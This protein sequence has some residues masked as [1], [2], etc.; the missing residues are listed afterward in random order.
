MILIPRPH[1]VRRFFSAKINRHKLALS[2]KE[3]EA[4]LAHY[5]LGPWHVEHTLAGGSSSDNMLLQTSRGPKVLKRYRCSLP[6]T[7]QEHSILR[8]LAGTDFP[9]PRLEVSRKGLTYTQLGDRHY[10]IY[11]FVDGYRCTDYFMPARTRER[12]VA[13]SGKTLA[14]LHQLMV[15]FVPD[16][17]KL[18]GFMPD[19]ERLWRDAVWHFDVL[20]QFTKHVTR[21]RLLDDQ[22][23][24]LLSIV[25][26]IKRDLITVGRHY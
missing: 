4:V 21:K 14:R 16:G 3:I 26:E 5:D 2:S 1:N 8:H 19:G 20:E 23:A 13:Q 6:S 17:R 24:F 25:D 12:L 7:K 18:R 22:D 9:F 11:D 10:A 15:G